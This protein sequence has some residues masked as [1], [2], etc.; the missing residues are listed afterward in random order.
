MTLQ[1]LAAL[2]ATIV[3]VGHGDPITEGA[4]DTLAEL[5]SKPVP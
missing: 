4:R 2:E 5:A 1:R 3:G